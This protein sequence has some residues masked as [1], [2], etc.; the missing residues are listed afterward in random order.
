MER[1]LVGWLLCDSN[2]L[3]MWN[4][5]WMN[6]CPWRH[7]GWVPSMF[8]VVVVAFFNCRFRFYIPNKQNL[9]AIPNSVTKFILVFFGRNF[10]FQLRVLFL[11]HLHLEVGSSFGFNYSLVLLDFFYISLLSGSSFFFC[12]R[13]GGRTYFLI[14]IKKSSSVWNYYP[15]PPKVTKK[16]A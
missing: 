16:K 5:Q 7:K 10:Q 4:T 2:E 8:F 14:L 15:R 9:F 3:V 13:R 6:E 1:G 12:K 11:L